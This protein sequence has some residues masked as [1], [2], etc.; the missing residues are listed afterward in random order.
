MSVRYE[1]EPYRNCGSFC[2]PK[3]NLACLEY[4]ELNH[5][6]ISSQIVQKISYKTTVYLLNSIVALEFTETSDDIR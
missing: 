2:N 6:V 1:K 5:H 4:L 3:C